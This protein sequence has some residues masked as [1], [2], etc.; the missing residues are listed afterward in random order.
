MNLSVAKKLREHYVDNN[1][2]HTHVSMVAPKGKFLLDREN[3]ENFW[4]FQ[5]FQ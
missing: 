1:P 2:W 5:V 3:L 4:D